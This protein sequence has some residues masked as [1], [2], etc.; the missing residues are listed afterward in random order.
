MG[1]RGPCAAGPETARRPARCGPSWS[2]VGRGPSAARPL[3]FLELALDCLALGRAGVAVRT[4]GCLVAVARR[5]LAGAVRAVA[6]TRRR[7][8]V[9]GGRDALE[10]LRERRHAAAD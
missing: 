2:M 6:T 10:D 4:L 5:S 8:L 7:G 1:R 9:G 3:D